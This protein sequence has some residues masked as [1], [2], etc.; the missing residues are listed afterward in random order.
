MLHALSVS[1][2]PRN[3]FVLSNP[4]DFLRALVGPKEVQILQLERTGPFVELVVEREIGVVS[5][6]TCGE[7]ARVKDRPRV[8]YVDL[9]VYGSPMT[10]TWKKHRL[11]C[12]N[13]DCRATS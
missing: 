13:G 8:S 4:N 7:R 5:C 9:P 10:L 6:P 2:K 1:K 3:T 12:V 11:R